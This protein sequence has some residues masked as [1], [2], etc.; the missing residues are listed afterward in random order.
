ME[1]IISFRKSQS[2]IKDA[3]AGQMMTYIRCL[4]PSL[5]PPSNVNVG[6]RVL[7]AS[8]QAGSSCSTTTTAAPSFLF[9]G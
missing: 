7:I 2:K 1:P 5:F 3:G 6:S 4:L 9:E 8:R